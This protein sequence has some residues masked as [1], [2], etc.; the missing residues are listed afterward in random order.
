MNSII[1]IIF[2][3]IILI[4]IYYYVYYYTRFHIIDILIS[5]IFHNL[6]HFRSPNNSWVP[7]FWVPIFG[8]IFFPVAM[9]TI[10]QMLSIL[11]LVLFYSTHY[12]PTVLSHGIGTIDIPIIMGAHETRGNRNN[13]LFRIA[14]CSLTARVGENCYEYQ[15]MAWKLLISN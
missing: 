2:L 12:C 7:Q 5:I 11:L 14:N 6:T 15:A 13:S 4:I 1:I 9:N 3:F 10:E 8:S